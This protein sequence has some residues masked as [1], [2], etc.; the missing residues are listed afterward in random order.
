MSHLSGEVKEAAFDGGFK[1]SPGL[2]VD[3]WVSGHVKGL[4]AEINVCL[5]SVDAVRC[6]LHP[7]CIGDD[8][9]IQCEPVIRGLQALKRNRQIEV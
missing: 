3:L 7:D 2:L 1:M 5:G 8:L 9:A 4:V 6:R